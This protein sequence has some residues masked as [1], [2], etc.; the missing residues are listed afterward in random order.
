VKIPIDLKTGEVSVESKKEVIVGIDLGTTNSLIAYMSEGN[1]VTIKSGQGKNAIVPSVIYFNETGGVEVGEV[2]KSRLLTDSGR[3]IFSVKRLMG[4]SYEDVSH[5]SQ[6]LGYDI[7]DDKTSPM[8]KIRVANRFFT[9]V[10]LSAEI[11]KALKREAEEFLDCP[12]EKAVITVPAYFNDAQRQATRDAGRLAGLDVLRIVNEPTAASLAYGIGLDRD[13]HMNIA[14]YDL[15]GGTFDIS[16]L[17]LEDGIFDV[18]STHGDTTLGGDDFDRCIM[19]HWLGQLNDKMGNVSTTPGMAQELRLMA[20]SA[21]KHLSYHAAYEGRIN[22]HPVAI[23]RSEFEELIWPLV[24]RTVE[25]CQLAIKDSGLKISEIG[26]VI[27]VGG[28]TRIPYIKEVLKSLFGLEPDDSMDPDEVVA[29][30]AA[31]QADILAGNRKDIL[32]LDVTPL[33]LGIETVGGLMDVIIPRNTKVPHRAGRSYTTSVDGQKNLRVSVFQG[34]RDLVADN[35]KLG[36]FTLKNIPPMPAG[37]PK[38]EVHFVLDA[39]GI[40]TVKASELR[41]GT[42]TSVEIRSAYGISEEEMAL[43]LLDSIRHAEEDLRMRALLES[44]NEANNVILSTERFIQQNSVHLSADEMERLQELKVQLAK[45]STE[46]SRDAIESA[47]KE[48][49]DYSSPIAHKMLDIN[50]NEALKGQKI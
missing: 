29:L 39:D 21:K 48:L 2:A 46:D 27:L 25:S 12:V 32:L 16:I 6:M 8:V 33:S 44:K 10:E 50:I 22:G 40:L 20:E 4:R 37:L 42:V 17:R 45:A 35:R 34:E 3:T 19:N 24:Q 1:P 11:L 30:G 15:G 49:N 23:T 47:M 28:S 26:K 5:L 41:S 7:I 13:Q 38:I 9:P 31:V 18:L 43:M 36:E 14:V